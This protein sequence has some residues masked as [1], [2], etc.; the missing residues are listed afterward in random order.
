MIKKLFFILLK[1]II[2]F[3]LFLTII[4][5]ILYY[6]QYKAGEEY[7][8]V[9]AQMQKQYIAVPSQ[10]NIDLYHMCTN[11]LKLY[12]NTT[13]T[14]ED[15]NNI[16]FA[17]KEQDMITEPIETPYLNIYNKIRNFFIENFE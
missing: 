8:L 3:I 14:M 5:G 16:G 11:E 6:I 9:V 2:A 10:Q 12:P 13:Y 4:Y 15:C 1:A 17:Y 7:N